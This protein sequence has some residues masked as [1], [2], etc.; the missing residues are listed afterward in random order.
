MDYCNNSSALVLVSMWKLLRQALDPIS[1]VL[2]VLAT[3]AFINAMVS[4]NAI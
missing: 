4:G 2:F 3:F 1:A